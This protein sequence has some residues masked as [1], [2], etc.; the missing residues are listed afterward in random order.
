MACFKLIEFFFVRF[1]RVFPA[2]RLRRVVASIDFV[3]EVRRWFPNPAFP[4]Q[5]GDPFWSTTDFEFDN[6][7]WFQTTTFNPL[8]AVIK[9][10]NPGRS[11]CLPLHS[12]DQ[13]A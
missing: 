6:S 9:Q 4:V 11:V 5:S 3:G 10:P 8:C 12:G 7:V 1:L 2:R 13:S